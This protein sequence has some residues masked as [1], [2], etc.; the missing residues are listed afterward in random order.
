MAATAGAHTPAAH[1]MGR[2]GLRTHNARKAVQLSELYASLMK[3]LAIDGFEPQL[4]R[5]DGHSTAGGAM[6]K[7]ALS[8]VRGSERIAFGYVDTVAARCHLRT[9]GRLEELHRQ[10]FDQ[11]LPIDRQGYA[12]L[13]VATADLARRRGMAV[14]L[15]EQSDEATTDRRTPTPDETPA[16]S[17]AVRPLVAAFVTVLVTALLAVASL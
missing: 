8:L 3:E 11:P 14:E 2:A 13:F 1:R 4:G 9:F 10:R 6:A 17:S 7:Q 12:A 16:P 15:E 5:P